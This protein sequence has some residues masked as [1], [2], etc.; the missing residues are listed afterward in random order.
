[1]WY[2]RQEALKRFAFFY[3]SI[4]LAGAFGGLLAYAIGHMEGL[5]GY[6]GWRWIFIVEG[7]VTASLA[8]PFFFL[9][10]DF[11]EDAK[12]VTPEERGYIRKRLAIDQGYSGLQRP[13]ALKDVVDMFS[14]WKVWIAGLLYF[15]CAMPGYAYSFFAPTIIK[16]FGY[17][18]V[19]TQLYSVAPWAGAWVFGMMTAFVS[20]RVRHRFGFIIMGM[21]VSIAGIATLLSTSYHRVH[22]QYGMMFMFI[23]GIYAALPVIVC[24]FNMNLGG[25][26]RRAIGGA[27]Q[28]GI[29]QVGGIVS[30]YTFLSKDAPNYTPGYSICLAFDVFTIFMAVAYFWGCRRENKKRDQIMRSQSGEGVVSLHVVGD[31]REKEDLGDRALDY[32]YMI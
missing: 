31:K 4:S 13:M 24:W 15:G 8:I 23:M 14:D 21:C 3:N 6:S 11:P 32:R 19:T 30:V 29:G 9:L 22:L 25:H 2:R 10:P 1:M 18:A 20:D 16:H 28:I 12:W 26:H 5:R 7:A 27:W 17:G